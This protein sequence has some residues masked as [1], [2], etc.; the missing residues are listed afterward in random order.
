V[1]VGDV[2]TDAS[3]PRI[4]LV[5]K[6]LDL[7]GI[8]RIVVDLALGLAARGVEVEVAVVNSNRDRL[9]PPLVDAG[10]IV[11]QL[12]GSDLIGVRAARRLIRLIRSGRYDLVHVHGPL[13][14]VVAR[15]ASVGVPTR[16]ITTAHTPWSSLR[17]PTRLAWAA[18]V[19]LDD[20]TVAVSAAVA[21]SLPRRAAARAIVVPHGVDPDR[22]DAARAA[23]AGRRSRDAAAPVTVVTVA[24]HRDAKN[25]P[26]LLRAVR[27]ALDAGANLRLVAI[28]DGPGKADHVE[29]ALRLGIDDAV[30]F[31]PSSD[32]V[33]TEIAA[34]D[35][36]VVASDHEGQPLVVAEALAL[37]VPVVATAVGRVPEMID[38]TVGRVVP[39][40]DAEALGVALCELAADPLQ[41]AFLGANAAQ[42]SVRSL[43]DVIDAHLVLYGPVVGGVAR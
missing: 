1:P 3:L 10:V 15:L 12:D 9:V 43:S 27:H 41:R 38:A 22:I 14:S 21:A 37:G 19:R 33:L 31:L 4:L 24:S 35:V 17:T 11:D 30:T 42:C 23:A 25:Y 5:T 8:E 28:G 20:A 2:V 6:G 26:N 16:V 13:P 36:L 29:L 39:P 32:Q 34:A 7:G 18:T 40:R